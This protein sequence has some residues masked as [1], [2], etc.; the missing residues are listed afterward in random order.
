MRPSHL[1][2]ASLRYGHEC[3]S[4]SESFG[5]MS[6]HSLQRSMRIASALGLWKAVMTALAI[7]L[8]DRRQISSFTL[9]SEAAT[10]PALALSRGETA[11]AGF[12]WMALMSSSTW[13]AEGVV[14]ASVVVWPAWDASGDSRTDGV[15][16]GQL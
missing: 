3:G 15:E 7:R 9:E 6:S 4:P 12:V 14:R 16:G 8:R 1:R 11:A 13:L 2:M 5:Q 10:E